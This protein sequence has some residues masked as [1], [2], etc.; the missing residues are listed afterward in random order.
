MLC[1]RL[2]DAF[3]LDSGLYCCHI[4]TNDGCACS[5]S[6]NLTIE[7]QS[8]MVVAEGCSNDVSLAIIKSPLPVLLTHHNDECVTNATATFCA[9]VYP[10]DAPVTWYVCGHPVVDPENITDLDYESSEFTVSFLCVCVCFEFYANFKVCILMSYRS[11]LPGK[12]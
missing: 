9:R 3:D 12:P 10:V 4:T 7:R 5:T 8:A 2:F 1:L 6:T 11:L